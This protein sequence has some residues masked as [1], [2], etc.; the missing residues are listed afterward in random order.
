MPCFVAGTK[1]P[2]VATL[3][4]IRGETSKLDIFSL[5]QPERP[6]IFSM[7]LFSWGMMADADIE[8]D[9][10][11]IMTMFSGC[12]LSLTPLGRLSQEHGYLTRFLLLPYPMV[13]TV[14]WDHCALRLRDLSG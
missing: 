5:S 7:L 4:L 10:Y 12:D 14:G 9:K 2:I 8:S 13:G 1:N 6:R 3:A 11:A